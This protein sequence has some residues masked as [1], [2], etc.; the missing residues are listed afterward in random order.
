MD[1]ILLRHGK[2]E[3]HHPD[4][5]AGRRLVDQGR[6]QAERAARLLK[7]AGRLPSIVLTS[8]YARARETA[9][10]FCKTA[11]MPGPLVQGWLV[12]GMSS[13]LA[14]GEVAGFSEF[15]SVMLVGHEPDF[16][17]LVADLLGAAAGAVQIKK[18]ALAGIRFMPPARGGVLKFLIPPKLSGSV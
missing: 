12:C 13:E 14:L 18:G 10:I 17:L 1:L 11:G 4:G 7:S 16:S 3:D 8:P 2:A 9:E 15:E 5:D 6:K